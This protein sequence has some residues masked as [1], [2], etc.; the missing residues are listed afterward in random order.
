MEK[1]ERETER[2]KSTEIGT[3][4]MVV[5]VVRVLDEYRFVVCIPIF[6]ISTHHKCVCALPFALSPRIKLDKMYTYSW[7]L[8]LLRALKQGQV[9]SKM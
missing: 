8:F 5:V 1:S 9:E 3:A 7:F 6:P 2:G 4:M